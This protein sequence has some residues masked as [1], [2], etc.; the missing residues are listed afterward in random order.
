MANTNNPL[1][2]VWE[3][4]GSI[5]K[6]DVQNKENGVAEIKI[7]IQS[8]EAEYPKIEIDIQNIDT[9]MTYKKAPV[10]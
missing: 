4:D 7:N 2:T 6:I 3:Q 10:Y 8:K 1:S 5:I 9:G